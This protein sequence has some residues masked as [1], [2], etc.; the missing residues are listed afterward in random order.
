MTALSSA[1][2][3]QSLAEPVATVVPIAYSLAEYSLVST[4]APVE[5]AH[6][7]E[8]P[9][10][11]VVVTLVPPTDQALLEKSDPVITPSTFTAYWL[12]VVLDAA[13]DV[14]EDALAVADVAASPALVVEIT[15]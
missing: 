1:R 12:A 3:A 6:S 5:I 11:A 8:A 10:L 9:R 2:T 4:A 15:A 13:L 7:L 14:A